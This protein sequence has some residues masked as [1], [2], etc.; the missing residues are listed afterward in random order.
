MGGVKQPTL[1]QQRSMAQRMAAQQNIG[2]RAAPKRPTLPGPMTQ[3][4]TDRM[5]TAKELDAAMPKQ[6][7]GQMAA[8][9]AAQNKT[10]QG[11]N[12]NAVMQRSM[13]QFKQALPAGAAVAARVPAQQA[14]QSPNLAA[15]NASQ[16]GAMNQFNQMA[17]FNKQQA[18]AQK[19]FTAM[20]NAPKMPAMRKGGAVK[21]KPGYAKG[22]M[23]MCGASMPPAQKGKK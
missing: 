14:Q 1:A 22:G 23:A 13:Q 21:K 20:A 17:A 6:A 16:Q 9:N 15:Y 4:E 3:Q 10:M 11:A 12:M 8:F 7:A 2:L 19:Q 18:D 5:K